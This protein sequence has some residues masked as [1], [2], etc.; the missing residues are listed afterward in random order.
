MKRHL[1]PPDKQ[2]VETF[3]VRVKEHVGPLL[4]PAVV[5]GSKARGEETVDSDVDVL[6]VL[7]REDEDVRRAVFD[8]AFEVFLETDVI[9]SPLV[10]TPERVADWKRS[11]RRLMRD[12]EREGVVV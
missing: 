3:L 5:F 2:A 12:V 9:L 10:M 8:I 11:A 6:L 7:G 4:S 1:A